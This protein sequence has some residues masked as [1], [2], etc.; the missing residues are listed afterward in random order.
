M[1]GPYWLVLLQ[2]QLNSPLKLEVLSLLRYPFKARLGI[3]FGL[4]ES[5]LGE[6]EHRIG[7]T[8]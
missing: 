3:Q 8:I 4:Q 1:M 5:S 2:V 6:P 7:V